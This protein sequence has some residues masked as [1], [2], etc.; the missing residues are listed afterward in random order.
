EVGDEHGTLQVTFTNAGDAVAAVPT[1]TRLLTEDGIA[2]LTDEA[3]D[4]PP[5]GTGVGSATSELPGEPANIP[6][7]ALVQIAS[8]VP[9]EITIAGNTAGSGGTNRLTAAVAQADVDRVREIA[10]EV[11]NRVAVGA[12][13]QTVEEEERGTLIPS[14]VTAA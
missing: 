4:V 5:A 11:L 9:P 14:S 12:L 6:A 8:E 2:Y 10:T 3:L 13:L 1:Q 7:S